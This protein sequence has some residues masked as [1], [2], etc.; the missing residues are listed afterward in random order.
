MFS[1]LTTGGTEQD[2]QLL[3]VLQDIYTKSLPVPRWVPEVPF[4]EVI[5]TEDAWNL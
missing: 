3:N 5:C 1:N 4:P 2:K